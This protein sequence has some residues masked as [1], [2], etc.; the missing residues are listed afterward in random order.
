MGL[1]FNYDKPGPGVD[2]N[3]PKK[4]GI[5]LYFELLWRNFGKMLLSNIIYFAVSLPISAVYYIFISAILGAALPTD[6]DVTIMVQTSLIMTLVLVALWGTGPVSCGLTYVLRSF[7]REEHTW[8]CSDFFG[9]SREGFKYGMV[10][11]IVDMAM[12]AAT[13]I[14]ASVYWSLASGGSKIYMLLLLVLALVVII[15]TAMH[16]YM[17]ELEVTFEGGIL[18]IYKNSLIMA[19]ATLPMC[20][21]ISAIIFFV[22]MNLL[23]FLSP[24]GVLLV[25]MLCWMSFMR[26]IVDFYSARVIKKNLISKR[27]KTEESD[28]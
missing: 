24:V 12:L 18:E 16:F 20:I 22:S 3:A 10:F 26:F 27:E 7:A 9:K 8:V 13:V 14:S 11:L 1:F 15:Y 21:L 17:Y 6:T 2:K 28:E 25:A 23:A 4:R 5:F 19:M